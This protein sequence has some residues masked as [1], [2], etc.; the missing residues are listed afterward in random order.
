MVQCVSKIWTS[1]TWLKFVACRLELIFTTPPAAS[2]N[3]ACFKSGQNRLKN[4]HLALLVLIRDTLCSFTNDLKVQGILRIF[5]YIALFMS[6]LEQHAGWSLTVQQVCV[7]LQVKTLLGSSVPRDATTEKQKI[8]FFYY[9][10][11]LYFNLVVLK[12][13]KR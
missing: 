13:M 12:M 5:S 9:T 10:I 3:D 11:Y 1:S 6:C 4:D 7:E 8:S 2:R